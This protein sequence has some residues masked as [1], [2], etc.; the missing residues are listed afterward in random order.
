VRYR[1]LGRIE[2]TD[3]DGRVVAGSGVAVLVQAET[4]VHRG[5]EPQWPAAVE[6]LPPFAGRQAEL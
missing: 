5:E 6:A 4:A 3:D 1:V 2:V